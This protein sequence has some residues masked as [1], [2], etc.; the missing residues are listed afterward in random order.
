MRSCLRFAVLLCLGFGARARR[1]SFPGFSAVDELV[2]YKASSP[3]KSRE[4]I[5]MGSSPLSVRGGASS[6]SNPAVFGKVGVTVVLETTLMLAVIVG[7]QKLAEET[8]IFPSIAG[9]PLIQW[10]GLFVIVFASSFLGSI[11]EGGL[12][13]A[14][15]Q[16][17]DPNATPGD[18][19]WYNKLE[20]PSWTPP[21]W[22]FPIMWLIISKPTQMIAL[23]K[24][25]KKATVMA[26]DLDTF[27]EL[28]LRVLGVY[29]AHLSFGDAW[30]KVFFGMQSIGRGAAVITM[31]LGL[32]L[33]STYLFYQVEPA[34][35]LFLLPTCGWVLAATALNWSIYLKNK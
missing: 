10:I 7:T 25:L 35:G 8:Q 13:V 2:E 26:S 15:N 24:I 21:G 34:A 14:T 11:V 22:L 20:K 12:N 19:Q 28:P 33:S 1:P 23:S 5:S 27:P 4:P 3:L 30:N 31:F 32:L 29:C 9:L 6:V 18:P 16:I 17:L